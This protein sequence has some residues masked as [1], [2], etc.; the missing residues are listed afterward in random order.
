M[1][2][3]GP[4]VCDYIKIEQNG[5]PK[6]E[7]LVIRTLRWDFLE[8]AFLLTGLEVSFKQKNKIVTSVPVDICWL[9]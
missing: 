3:L 1:H 7:S 6:R 4:V 8:I 5:K 2:E 9:A